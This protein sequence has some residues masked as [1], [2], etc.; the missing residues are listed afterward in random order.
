MT[1]ITNDTKKVKSQFVKTHDALV[2]YVIE[3]DKAVRVQEGIETT[4][5]KTVGDMAYAFLQA[6]YSSPAHFKSPHTNKDSPITKE[7]WSWLLNVGV[8]LLPDD[9]VKYLPRTIKNGTVFFEHGTRDI[10]DYA[11]NDPIRELV[12]NAGRQP[13]SKVGK[14]ATAVCKWIAELEAEDMT[15]EEKEAAAENSE[16]MICM[17]RWQAFLKACENKKSQAF[18][19]SIQ[20]S[21]ADVTSKLSADGIAIAND[22]PSH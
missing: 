6:G 1:T 9:V 19:K 13:A 12:Q 11:K 20:A 17:N 18:C 7:Q 3:W 16:H 2:E 10:D 4:V 15:D 5:T 14:I 22:E 21:V 8:T